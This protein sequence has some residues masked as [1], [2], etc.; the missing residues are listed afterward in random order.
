MKY[1]WTYKTPERFD[2]LVMCG[3]DE[4]LTGLWFEGSRDDRRYACE[5]E[6][7]KTP[8]FRGTCR[9]LTFISRGETQALRPRIAWKG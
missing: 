9:G 3:D 6:R 8:V 5:C 1:I 2:D 7:R 4:A